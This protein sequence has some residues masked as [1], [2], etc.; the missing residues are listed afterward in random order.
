MPHDLCVATHVEAVRTINWLAPTCLILIGGHKFVTDLYLIE[1]W[2]YNVILDIDW[3]SFMYAVGDYRRKK[4]YFHFP[5]QEEFTFSGSEGYTPSS[6]DLFPTSFE[7][8]Q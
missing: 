3:L 6:G 8:D 5:N 2:D 4:V 1:L 7:I